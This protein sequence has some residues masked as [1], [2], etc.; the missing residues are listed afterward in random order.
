MLRADLKLIADLIPPN[1]RVLDLG[2]GDGELLAFLAEERGCTGTGVEHDP[3]AVLAAISRGVPVIELDLDTQT[4]EFRDNS[5]DVVILSRTLQ[6]VR[7]PRDVLTEMA[8]M[9]DRAIVS[10]PNFG[11]WRN[12]LRLLRGRMPMSKD[13]PFAWYDTPNLHHSTLTDLEPL[14]ASCGLD[15][16]R[17]IPL[18]EDGKPTHLGQRAANLLA[19]AA[20]YELRAK[21][22][23]FADDLRA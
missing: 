1:S 20:L 8:R 15:V 10:M 14:F 9:G 12:R 4:D 23:Q 11:F 13:L 18:A 7:R 16:V 2:C 17:R 5:F 19:G 22:D 6:A 3:A 21:P